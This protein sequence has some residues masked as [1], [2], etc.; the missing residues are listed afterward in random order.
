MFGND[1][2]GED[3]GGEKE[4]HVA[5][6]DFK[7]APPGPRPGQ[8]TAQVRYR[9][10]LTTAT[11]TSVPLGQSTRVRGEEDSVIARPVSSRNGFPPE[12]GKPPLGAF[13]RGLGGVKLHLGACSGDGG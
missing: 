2:E 9:D 12:L 1:D 3:G 10:T 6:K 5:R 13:A 4:V 8:P 7:A 11:A